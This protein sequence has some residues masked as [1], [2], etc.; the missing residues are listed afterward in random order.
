MIAV[1]NGLNEITMETVSQLDW[2]EV[3]A[4]MQKEKKQ[5][6]VNYDMPEETLRNAFQLSS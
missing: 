2:T 5:I 1:Y 3:L 4:W 6:I